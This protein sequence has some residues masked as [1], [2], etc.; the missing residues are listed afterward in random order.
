VKQENYNNSHVDINVVPE[1]F[2]DKIIICIT[3]PDKNG[4]GGAHFK[5]SPPLIGY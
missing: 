5:I 4:E 1:F 3:F 2:D